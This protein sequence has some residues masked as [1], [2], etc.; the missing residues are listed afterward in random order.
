MVMNPLISVIVP[1]YNHKKE[2]L[3][4]LDSL[5]KQ[6]YR[7]FEIIVID[8]CSD[9]HITIDEFNDVFLL[10]NEKRM[11]PCF[12]RNRGLAA[13]KGE[14]VIF[15]DSDIVASNTMLTEM[16]D[17]LDKNQDASFVYC[18]MLFGN[19]KMPG[20]QFDF[21]FLKKRNYISIAS[22]IRRKD[23]IKFDENLK[24]FQDWDVWL[25]MAEQGKSGLWINKYLYKV[26][27][28][29]DGISSWVPRWV[30]C[31]PFKFLPYFSEKIAKY[32]EAKQILF[33]KHGISLK[34]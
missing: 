27:S 20:R 6:I 31:F 14:Y 12:S 26:I 34:V 18:N 22:L 29:K 16:K 30:Y 28:K 9:E 10:R 3:I 19:K 25:T 11:G 17:A 7:P 1:V 13:S 4:S 8:D 23:A 33:K 21:S 15:F 5:L 32:E 2:F 24:R